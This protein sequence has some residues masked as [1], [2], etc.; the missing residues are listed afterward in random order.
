MYSAFRNALQ[1]QSVVLVSDK[2]ENKDV[3][4]HGKSNLVSLYN[5]K[6]FG[7]PVYNL[8]CCLPQS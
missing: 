1:I 8:Q 2:I 7:K 3:I 5:W 6:N 4:F